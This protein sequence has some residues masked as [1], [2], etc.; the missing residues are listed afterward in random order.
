MEVEGASRKTELEDWRQKLSN[1]E[2]LKRSGPQMKCS[3][4]D[5]GRFRCLFSDS[6]FE[7]RQ[8]QIY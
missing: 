3:S 5:H 2:Y 8:I 6:L 1:Y 7:F 4:I